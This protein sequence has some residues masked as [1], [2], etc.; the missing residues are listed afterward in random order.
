MESV[1]C[2]YFHLFRFFHSRLLVFVLMLCFESIVSL[3]RFLCI[4]VFSLFFYIFFFF[5]FFHLPKR[6]RS[7][8]LVSYTLVLRRLVNMN[9]S[10]QSCPPQPHLW[11]GCGGNNYKYNYCYISA[12]NALLYLCAYSAY[13]ST[14]YMCLLYVL[15]SRM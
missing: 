4:F 9:F 13:I 3:F 5:C 2:F 1:T 12:F 15:R 14:F 11:S 10:G 8:R 7:R 6:A